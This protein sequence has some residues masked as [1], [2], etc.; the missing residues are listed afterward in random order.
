MR[1][2]LLWLT[3]ISCSGAIFVGYSGPVAA[4]PA[5]GAS[6]FHGWPNQP[7]AQAMDASLNQGNPGGVNSPGSIEGISPIPSSNAP[8]NSLPAAGA[9]PP[10]APSIQGGVD[11]NYL[12]GPGDVIQVDVFNVPEYSG[13][14]QVSTEGVISL[15][16]GRLSVMNKN[17][18]QAES[19]ITVAYGTELQP[20][21]V[22]VSV[23]QQR[24][25]QISVIGEIVQPGLYTL[26]ASDGTR[27]PTLFEILQTAGGVTQAA[28]LKSVE[29]RRRVG[30][31][32][33]SPIR[34]DLLAL[35]EQGDI[36]QNVYLRDGDT[37]VIPAA[38]RVAMAN[39]N[40]LAVS[41]IRASNE[42]PV[43]IAIVGEVIRPGPYRMTDGQPTV[44]QA[45]QQA[46]GITTG[47]DL[48]EIE[49]RRKTRQGAE[50]V[51]TINLWDIIRNGDL[52]QDLLLQSGD[53]ISVPTAS[54]NTVADITSLASSSL[55]TGTIPINIIGEVESP[56]QREVQ[57]NTSLNEA[58]LSAGGLNRRATRE[59]SLIRFNPNGSVSQRDITLDLEQEVNSETNPILKPD[60]VIVV[61]RNARAA[62]TDTF[63][64]WAGT[65]NLVWPFILLGL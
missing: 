58:V 51:V 36:N 19:A 34:V 45:I 6:D 13:T 1:L 33:S 27:Y 28:D 2:C 23:I 21:I 57:A 32:Q 14:F 54:S 39:L 63:S 22:S 17:T 53:V 9:T 44:V 56:G 62:F 20:P 47:A 18:R 26:P 4:A 48:R 37:V 50:Q 35:L 60:D 11:E 30:I 49:L 8:G 12:L 25:L 46:G 38:E 24:P 40:Q 41:N 61:G 64:D 16:T 7:L 31:S 3:S 5:S 10:V 29:I 43:D 15:P 42:L 55:S 65:F 59:V 52:N